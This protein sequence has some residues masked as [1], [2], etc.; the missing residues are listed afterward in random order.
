[1]A[2]CASPRPQWVPLGPFCLS[3]SWLKFQ[4][5]QMSGRDSGLATEPSGVQKPNAAFQQ[6]I[7]CSSSQDSRATTSFT[8]ASVRIRTRSGTPT[9][10]TTPQICPTPQTAPEYLRHSRLRSQSCSIVAPYRQT[11]PP[12]R[13]SRRITRNL[14]SS[15]QSKMSSRTRLRSS[16]RPHHLIPFACTKVGDHMA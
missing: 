12:C 2:P 14:F 6:H 13:S 1:M 10:P 4:H 5:G 11:P 16:Q 8:G 3:P 15:R 7:V 9:S